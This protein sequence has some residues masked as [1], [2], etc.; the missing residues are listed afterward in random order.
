MIRLATSSDAVALAPLAR[1]YAAHEGL[2]PRQLGMLNVALA[3][4][5]TNPDKGLLLVAIDTGGALVG[6]TALEWL[7]ASQGKVGRS[8]MLY[9]ADAARGQG[10]G[11]ALVRERERHARRLGAQ[12]LTTVVRGANEPSLKLLATAGYGVESS[13][14]TLTKRLL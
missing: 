11:K 13:T 5:L 1:G 2:N 12:A 7:L 9:V 10:F 3:A 6:A 8:F 14:I 4:L